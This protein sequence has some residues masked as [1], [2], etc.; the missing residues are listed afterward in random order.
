[1]KKYQ[2]SLI[3]IGLILAMS[4]MLNGANDYDIELRKQYNKEF[5]SNASTVVEIGNRY[6]KVEVKTWD[7]SLVKIEVSI[8]VKANKKSNAQSKLDAITVKFDKSGNNVIAHTDISEGSNSW[9]SGWWSS[10]NNVKYEINYLV[11]MPSNLHSIIENK[12]GNIYLPDLNA[13]TSISLKYGNLEGR[14]ID[15]DLMINL[16][17]GKASMGKVSTLSGSISYSDYRGIS[18]DVV[19]LT[20]KYSKVYI[21]NSNSLTAYSKYDS[22][23][24]GDITNLNFTG[25]YDDLQIKSLSTGNCNTKYSGIDINSLSYI[26][27]ADLSYGSINIDNLKTSLKSITISSSYAP[28]KIYG[29]VPAKVDISGKYFDA[30]LG[31]DFISK[32]VDKDGSSKTINGYKISDRT[33]ATINITTKYG[34]IYMK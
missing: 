14:N 22:Y 7:K 15:G 21:D 34:D 25:A 18:A 1:M 26:L 19:V 10:D 6:G 4:P 32:N 11:Y 27:D 33:N 2:F 9:W 17:Y 24:L 30:F 16:G 5:S 31:A 3:I 8:I 23:K 29:M 13:K 12:Y 20:S 28:I